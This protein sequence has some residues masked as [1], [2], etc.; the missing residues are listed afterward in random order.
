MIGAPFESH[1]TREG[2]K[3]TL[4]PAEGFARMLTHH[5]ERL[6]TEWLSIFLACRAFAG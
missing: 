2:I 3:Q 4:K 6:V 1:L 5:I